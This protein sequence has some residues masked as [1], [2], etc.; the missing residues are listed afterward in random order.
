MSVTASWRR[1]KSGEVRLPG[2]VQWALVLLALDMF[3]F[4]DAIADVLGFDQSA[5]GYQILGSWYRLDAP[6]FPWI[7]GPL[8]AC[9][10]AAVWSGAQGRRF[11]FVFAV[12]IAW[13]AL[14]VGAITQGSGP[15]LLVWRLIIV[16]L[17]LRGRHA[18]V[19]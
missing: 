1:I 12:A 8:S 14:A 18:F 19:S 2:S 9:S 7:V 13:T 15:G 17:L 4:V 5:A 16:L 3:I 6:V 10:V 11:W